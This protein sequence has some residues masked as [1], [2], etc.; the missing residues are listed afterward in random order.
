M[1]QIRPVSRL[2]DSVASELEARILD[3]SL[4]PGDL[5][6]SERE[7]A[8]ELGVSRP[9][10]REAIQKLAAK[11]LLTTH[12]GL[13]TRVTDRL[14]AHFADPWQ[15]MFKSHPVLQRDLLEFRRMLET[16]AAY[17]AAERAV[18][19]DIQRLDAAYQDLCAAYDDNDT[20]ARIDKDVQFHQTIAE[21]SHNVLIGHL[22]ASLMRVIHS[23]ISNNMGFLHTQ[24][25][26]WTALK[27]QHHAIW[28]AIR[29]H[30]PELAANAARDHVDF[31]R[32]T[33]AE[34]AIDNERR[35]AAKRRLG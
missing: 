35:H 11:G 14:E 30:Q 31:V 2:T 24:P 29:D 32:K 34:S 17:L 9:P 18:D 25:T 5:L 26:N 7:L 22:T 3:G 23:D 4:K 6:P 19:N 13:G 28:Q 21:A 10:I 8:V 33:I 27:A 15:D 16:Q 1:Q 12:H 20:Q